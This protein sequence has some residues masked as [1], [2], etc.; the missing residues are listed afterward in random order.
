MRLYYLTI[1]CLHHQA[2][3]AMQHS[4]FTKL[5]SGS[6]QA[7]VHAMSRCFYSDQL[8]GLL[9]QEMIEH[10]RRITATTY[11]GND[12][13]GQFTAGLYFQLLSCFFTDHTLKAGH[14]IRVRM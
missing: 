5:G 9:I 13:R 12:V 11:A 6:A 3:A 2:L 8:H 10:T 4:W 1:F 14:H 7:A